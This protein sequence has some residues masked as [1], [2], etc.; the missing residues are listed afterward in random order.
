MLEGIP[1]GSSVVYSVLAVLMEQVCHYWLTCSIIG[2]SVDILM[3]QCVEIICVLLFCLSGRL[4]V[5]VDRLVL[6][7]GILPI[8]LNVVLLGNFVHYN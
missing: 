2:S 4:V 7:V 1:D 3:S 5:S 8:V 6:L